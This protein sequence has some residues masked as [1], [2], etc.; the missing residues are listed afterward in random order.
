MFKPNTGNIPV[1][2]L[3]YIKA[4]FNSID[5]PFLDHKLMRPFGSFKSETVFLV[6][7]LYNT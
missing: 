3:T 1:G 7:S 5:L 2:S 4:K 6:F